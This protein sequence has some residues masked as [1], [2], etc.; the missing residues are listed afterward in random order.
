L[1]FNP[2]CSGDQ[3]DLHDVVEIFATGSAFAAM[4][5]DGSIVTW[6]HSHWGGDSSA[7][8]DLL[9]PQNR[10]RSRVGRCKNGRIETTKEL[11]KEKWGLRY[12]QHQ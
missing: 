1:W 8:C 11:I 9:R 12:H 7:V 3:D 4:R 10:A 2:E 5:L 6:G